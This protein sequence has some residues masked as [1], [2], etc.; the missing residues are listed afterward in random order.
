[1]IYFYRT[2]SYKVFLWIWLIDG[3]GVWLLGREAYH[4]GASGL[5][6]GMASFLFFSGILR[7]NRSLL[8]LSLAVVFVYGSLIWGD[9]SLHA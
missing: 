8:A 3:V 5:V 7:K 1:M 4:I 9:V 2:I 6:Y